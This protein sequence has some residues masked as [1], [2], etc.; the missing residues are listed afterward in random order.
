M[1]QPFFVY[2]TFKL[3]VHLWLIFPSSKYILNP[4]TAGS[5]RINVEEREKNE[6]RVR[7]AKKKGIEA[8]RALIGDEEQNIKKKKEKEN[9]GSGTPNVTVTTNEQYVLH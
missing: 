9:A 5:A 2:F 8:Q 3:S 7:R 4:T 1:S 6:R